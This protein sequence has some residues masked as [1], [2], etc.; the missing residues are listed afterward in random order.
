MLN[1][2]TGWH[3]LIILVIVLLLF[4][5]PKLPGLARSLGQSMKIFKNEIKSDKDETDLAPHA[6]GSTKAAGP[7]DP[8][9]KS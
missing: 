1:N 6:D 8:T 2:L 3:F 5:A 9:T 7:S 4:G